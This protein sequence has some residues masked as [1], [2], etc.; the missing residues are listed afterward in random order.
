MLY[1][2]GEVQAIL[3]EQPGEAYLKLIAG[4][5]DV[6]GGFLLRR[7]EGP[8]VVLFVR[9]FLG[10]HGPIRSRSLTCY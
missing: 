3:S 8:F 2:V 7:L 5:H 9:Q 10:F 6:Q 1:C 4:S